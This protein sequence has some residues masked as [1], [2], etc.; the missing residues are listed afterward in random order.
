MLVLTR[1]NAGEF[2]VSLASLQESRDQCSATTLI[3]DFPP[4]C[5]V[6]LLPV[7]CAAWSHLT[8]WSLLRSVNVHVQSSTFSFRRREPNANHDRIKK[9]LT[10]GKLENSSHGRKSYNIS[11]SSKKT[12]RNICAK[13][14]LVTK[15]IITINDSEMTELGRKHDFAKA[16]EEKSE[17]TE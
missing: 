10:E 9:K 6:I 15:Y 17:T 7:P 13:N 4:E 12:H 14:G 3:L 5:R 8:L 11:A 2:P 16:L 1:G